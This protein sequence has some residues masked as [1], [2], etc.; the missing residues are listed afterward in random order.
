[1][2]RL[3]HRAG[4]WSTE[5]TFNFDRQPLLLSAVNFYAGRDAFGHDGR[6]RGPANCVPPAYCGLRPETVYVPTATGTE[7]RPF[8][9]TGTMSFVPSDSCRVICPLRARGPSPAGPPTANRYVDSNAAGPIQPVTNCAR[10]IVQ[11]W[12]ATR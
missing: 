1:M 3:R 8:A 9:P 7:N 10:P 2:A 6:S 5:P 11:G 12:R 4:A